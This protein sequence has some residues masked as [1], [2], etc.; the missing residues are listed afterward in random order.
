M[1]GK[2]VNESIMLKEIHQQP[3]KIR[4]T[5]RINS[6]EI[7]SIAKKIREMNPKIIHFAARGSSEHACITAKYLFEIVCGIPCNI[8]NPSIITAYN[9]KY[10]LA[11]S[12]AIGVSQCGEAPDVVE[13]LNRA[14]ESG[15][16]TIGITNTKGSPIET[17][18]EHSLNCEAGPEVCVTATKSYMTQLTL[19][20]ALAAHVSEDESLLAAVEKLADTVQAALCFE[21]EV[22]DMVRYFHCC[23]NMFLIARGYSVGVVAEAELK[24]QETCY[25]RAMAYSSADYTHGP[26]AMTGHNS[27]SIFVAADKHTDHDIDALYKRVLERHV[28]CVCITNK[29]E[30]A[31]RFP[32]AILLPHRCEGILGSFAAAVIFQFFASYLS[33]LKGF[34][35]DAPIGVSKRTLTK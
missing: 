7:K 19:L 5:L 27:P 11:N 4:E 25:V 12:V 31:D 26:F 9:S 15:G 29:T 17:V 28:L 14:K 1:K 2:I 18:S 16:L 24:I 3:E 10:N 6:D 20:T 32:F 21:D 35:P 34:N 33:I 30:I 23:D 22:A 13:V 8:F